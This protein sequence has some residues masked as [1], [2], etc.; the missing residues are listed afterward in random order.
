MNEMNN[1]N[2]LLWPNGHKREKAIS[3]QI[4]KNQI[5]SLL[6]FKHFLINSTLHNRRF[7]IDTI[8]LYSH[9]GIRLDDVDVQ[10]FQQNQIVIYM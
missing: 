5:N 2:I 8:N 1:I 10:N 7:T 6:S 4:N 3:L 9:N